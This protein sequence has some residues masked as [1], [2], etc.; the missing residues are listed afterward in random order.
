MKIDLIKQKWTEIIEYVRIQNNATEVSYQTWLS[1]LKPTYFDKGERGEDR[2]HIYVDVPVANIISYLETRFGPSFCVAIGE[3]CG[4]RCNVVFEDI[5]LDNAPTPTPIQ[6]HRLEMDELS[7]KA[8]INS[9]YTFDTFVVGKSNSMAHAAAIAVANNNPSIVYNPL[10]I[11]GGVGLGKTHLMHAVANQIIQKTPDAKILYVT[12]EEFTNDLID[13][14]RLRNNSSTAEF[15]KKYRKNDLLLIDD[16]QF[17]SGKESTQEEFF[18]TFNSLYEGKKQII[19]SSDRPPKE[20][21]TLAERLRSRFESGLQVDIQ[22]PDYETRMAILRKREELDG[23][24]IDNSVMQYIAKNIKSNI[25]ELEGALNR[26]VAYGNLNRTEVNEALAQ[27]VLKDIISPSAP[28]KITTDLII[29]IVA[30]HFSLSVDDLLGSKRTKEVANPRQIVMYLCQELTNLSLV[31]IGK[32]L[33]N[34]D[35]TTIIHGAKKISENLQDDAE[36]SNHIEV[37]RKKISPH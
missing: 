27:E 35:H 18:H 28:T 16:I 17:I 32:A 1:P 5:L 29:Q 33:G 4:I 7:K 26:I 10:F 21:E 3:T 20:L 37:I 23:L 24:N 14:I 8:N 13:A 31:Q 36:L 15:R 25:R 12:S 9:R 19:I 22:S 30:E 11:Y 34:R 2:L 6:K